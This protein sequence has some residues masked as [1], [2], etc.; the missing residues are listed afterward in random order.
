MAIIFFS[1]WFILFWLIGL[2]FCV[3]TAL[4]FAKY[5]GWRTKRLYVGIITAAIYTLALFIF[6]VLVAGRG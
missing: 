6:L 5:Y 3:A 2:V 1:L 4:H